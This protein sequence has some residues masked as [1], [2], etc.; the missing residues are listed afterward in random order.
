MNHH[1]ELEL[2]VELA[3]AGNMRR[4]AGALGI[5]QSTLSDC[6]T[7]L[8]ASYG[9][10]LFERDRRGSTPTVYGKVVISAAEQALRLMGEAR[11]EIGLIKGS[12]RGRLAIGFDPALSDPFLSEAIARGLRRYP[13]LRYRLQSFDSSTLVREVR[14]K[15]IDFFFG[16][17]PDVPTG[18]LELIELAVLKGVPFVRRGHPLASATKPT[19]REIMGFP[20]VQGPGPRWFVRR[21]TDEPRLD[22]GYADLRRNAAVVVNDFGVVRSIVRQTDAVGFAVAPM[23]QGEFERSAFALIELP[24]AQQTLF[25]VSVLIGTLEHRNLPPSARGLIDEVRAVV[26]S[27]VNGDTLAA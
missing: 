7:R 23:L 10:L 19:L 4:A 6:I 14:E 27:Y 18:G 9:A 22:V 24:E 25:R 11:R 15:R 1:E 3:H 16:I 21:M 26:R 17:T 12:A 5:S 20:V 13:S 8:E 2:L